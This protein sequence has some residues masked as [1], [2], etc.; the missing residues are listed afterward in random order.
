MGP[1][2]TKI[3]RPNGLDSVSFLTCMNLNSSLICE[4]IQLVMQYVASKGVDIY[5]SKCLD[6]FCHF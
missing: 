4:N 1:M 6:D 3:L 2:V 5:Y